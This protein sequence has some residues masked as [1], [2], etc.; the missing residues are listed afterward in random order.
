MRKSPCRSL[1]AAIL[2]IG[3]LAGAQA[4]ERREFS[5]EVLVD[6][7]PLT[8]YAASGATYVEAL[9]GAEYAVRLRNHTSGRVAVALSVDGLNSI[10]A[11]HTSA[12]QAAKWI[13]GPYE[14]VTIEGWQTGPSTARRFFFTTEDRS[15]GAWLG[16]T[17]NLGR[18]SAA[19]FKERRPRPRPTTRRDEGKSR[20]ALPGRDELREE[21]RREAPGAPA[22]GDTA[23]EAPLDDDLAA[24][25][26]G[27]ELDHPVQRVEFAA[28]R[29]AAER[30]SVRY[31]YRDALVRLGVL[32]PVGDP[33]ARRDRSRGF[34]DERFAP[35]PFRHRDRP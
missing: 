17:D 6:G 26:I 23:R 1:M 35:D 4:V 5:M 29:H 10:D 34:A 24:T 15:Y 22:A 32:P 31:E 12:E 19:F 30:L 28:E 27:R 2:W 25:G 20:Q 7:R 16:E 33:L 21:S 8:E 9:P 13:L 11:K 18:I 14:T 3:V